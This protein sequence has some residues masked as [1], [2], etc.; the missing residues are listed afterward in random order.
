MAVLVSG[1][2]AIDATLVT[3]VFQLGILNFYCIPLKIVTD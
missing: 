3:L 2:A 1:F